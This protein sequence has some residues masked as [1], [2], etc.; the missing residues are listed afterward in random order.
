MNICKIIGHK[1][2]NVT[3]YKIEGIENNILICSRCGK[4]FMMKNKMVDIIKEEIKMGEEYIRGYTKNLL[5]TPNVVL[6]AIVQY[7][8]DN[9]VIDNL[10]VQIGILKEVLVKYEEQK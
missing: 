7:P 3:T 9:M 8:A 6:G 10:K 5:K 4:M 1:I 2:T